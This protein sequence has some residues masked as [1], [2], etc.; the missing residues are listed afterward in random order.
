MQSELTTLL[1]VESEMLQNWVKT[2]LA[3]ATSTANNQSIRETIQSLV[4]QPSVMVEGQ[5]NTSDIELRR[6]LERQ[7]SPT[8]S[9]HDFAGYVVADKSQRIVAAATAELVGREM[10]PEFERAFSKALKGEATI[11]PPFGSVVLLRDETGRL[12]SGVPS[13]LACAPVRNTD[14]QVIGVLALRIRPELEFSRILELGRFGDTGETYAFNRTGT[15]VSNSRFD[16]ELILAGVLPDRDD[17]RSI[18]TVQLRD[19][20]GNMLDGYRPEVRRAKQPFTKSAAAA[21]AGETGVDI[22]GYRDYRGVDRLGA[23]LWIDEY[24]M[25]IVTEI[26]RD[27]AY[28]PLYIL[29]LT[30]QS[31][32]VLLAVSSV[33]I[34]LF[35]IRVARLKQEAQRAAIELKQLGQYELGE[36]LGA[37]GMGVVYKGH[38]A[39]M[40]R[41][42]AIKLLNIEKVNDA[43][44]QRFE[45][46]VQITCQLNHP[47]TIA[48]FDYGRTP[49]GV[50]YY[51]MEFLD[52]IDLQVLIE[53]YGPQ[54]EGRVIRILR[55]ICGSLFEAHSLGLVHRDIK[56]ANVMINRRGAETDVVKVLDFGLVKALD[57]SKQA[58]LTAA[59]SLAGT[60]LY[61]APE[62]I[63]SPNSVDPRSDLYAVGA[64]GYFLL[65]GQTV[66]EAETIIQLCQKHI[67]GVPVPPSQRTSQKISPQ[68][69]EILLSCLDKVRSRR[70]ESA[71]VL[72]RLL[73]QIP[74]ESGWTDED[75]EAWWDAHSSGREIPK[76]S[77]SISSPA[78]AAAPS[79]DAAYGHTVVDQSILN[80]PH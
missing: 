72:S 25:G 17:A 14:F 1:N 15:M 78:N 30:F 42:A 18:L 52:G 35:T 74:S 45:R 46:E 56:P 60:P 77:A 8:L 48:I 39:M 37:G 43:S 50:F 7:L 21:M 3:T 34:F 76:P 9:S 44:I 6:L 57:E 75:A 26:D 16:E 65:T 20:G 38:H 68:L 28:R 70:P 24:D 47:N 55:Q 12:R 63:Q 19:P 40:R 67:D 54:P 36:K 80:D 13:M 53:R 29:K 27:E 66:F 73:K 33:A 51:A 61:M 2:N 23:W 69:E 31:L 10:I 32:L 64:L 59:N 22:E 4:E 58:G 62:A 71:R 41:P 79:T 49:E 11:T 5:A